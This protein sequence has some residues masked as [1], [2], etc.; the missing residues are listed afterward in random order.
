MNEDFFIFSFSLFILMSIFSQPL[1]FES[2]SKY[3]L[4]VAVENEAPFAKPLPTS[5]ATVIVNVEDLNEAPV[6]DP[7]EKLI[8]KPE[9]VAVGTELT[10]YTATDPDTAKSQKVT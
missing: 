8:S 7:L 3:T 2:N 10:V 9:D 4:L 6:F 5:T 1:D